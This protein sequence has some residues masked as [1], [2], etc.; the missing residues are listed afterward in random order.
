MLLCCTSALCF[1]GLFAIL[2]RCMFLQS[3][4]RY[5]TSDEAMSL[6]LVSLLDICTHPVCCTLCISGRPAV[7]LAPSQLTQEEQLWLQVSGGGGSHSLASF[8]LH[9]LLQR[10]RSRSSALMTVDIILLRF[11]TGHTSM[12][13]W[14]GR[15]SCEHPHIWESCFSD[16]NVHPFVPPNSEGLLLSCFNHGSL[17]LL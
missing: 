4:I 16:L 17:L 5:F 10:E 9:G 15:K 1:K 14:M 7:S 11:S 3:V 8:G 2:R 12:H 13:R 6:I